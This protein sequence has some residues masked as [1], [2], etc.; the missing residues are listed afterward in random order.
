[1]IKIRTL[2]LKIEYDGTR[3]GG[4][5]IQPNTISIQSEIKSALKKLTDFEFIVTGAG[6]TDAGVHARG[7]VASIRIDN[8]FHIP[9]S[10]ISLA[11]NSVLPEDIKIIC[12]KIINNDF[13]ARF[14]AIAREY[15]YFIHLKE[16]VFKRNYSL[17]YKYPFD[18]NILRE[19]AEVFTGEHNFTTFS[20][21]NSSTV[22]YVCNVEIAKWDKINDFSYRFTI[23]SDRFVYGMVRAIVGAMLD[24]SRGKRT[25]NDL[26]DT[27]LKCDRSYI[28]P[29]AQPHGLFLEKIYYPEEIFKIK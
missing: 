3:Y 25:I 26:R 15:S 16:D 7:Q 5:Q 17:L 19:S 9:E 10:K 13:H 2:A 6:R 29:L 21:F 27:L 11:I 8:N 24:A 1:V 28:S 20:K 18:F 23:K 12:A 22:N 4:W 14:D